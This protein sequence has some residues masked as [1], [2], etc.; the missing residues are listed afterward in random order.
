[1]FSELTSAVNPP[2][3]GKQKEYLSKPD[4]GTGCSYPLWAALC[5][6]WLLIPGA[7]VL[8]DMVKRDFLGKYSSE[9]STLHF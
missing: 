8:G 2:R 3:G 4:L 6:L 9:N 5:V 7:A 1:M